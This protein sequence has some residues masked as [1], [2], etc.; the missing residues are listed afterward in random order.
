MKK[1]VSVIFLALCVFLLASCQTTITSTSSITT[2]TTTST[3]TLSTTAPK[4]IDSLT[5]EYDSLT[6]EAE[7]L[8]F[9][10][11]FEELLHTLHQDGFVFPSQKPIYVKFSPNQYH[12]LLDHSLHL[13]KNSTKSLSTLENIFFAIYGNFANYGLVY[14]LSR[15]YGEK[16]GIQME[17]LAE[18]SILDE[19]NEVNQHLLE[20]WYVGFIEPYSTPEESL[21]SKQLAVQL[22]TYLIENHGFEYIQSLLSKTNDL[23]EFDLAFT[24][25]RNQWLAYNESSIRVEVRPV[26]LAFGYEMHWYTLLWKSPRATWFLYRDYEDYFK[27]YI[28]DSHMFT[29]S[30]QE[31]VYLITTLEHQMAEMDLIF[32]NTNLNPSL[33]YH[34]VNINLIKHNISYFSRHMF[35]NSLFAFI[36]EYVHYLSSY[37]IEPYRW[38]VEGIAE[39][40]T[41]TYGYSEELITNLHE[42][43]DYFH[44]I[45]SIYREYTNQSVDITRDLYDVFDYYIF[46]TDDYNKEIDPRMKG[47]SFI[48]YFIKE[49]GE[50]TLFLFIRNISN[51]FDLTGKT[52]EELVEDWIQDVKSRFSDVSIDDLY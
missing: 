10:L 2:T 40:Y 7:L 51:A 13:Y 38:V 18:L 37:W 28:E 41:S 27:D 45:T 29:S 23:V 47:V 46:T 3:S 36:H 35:V 4:I 48:R 32:K 8:Q 17:P 16:L 26:P 42:Q 49:Y 44:P 14:G 39:Y 21:L 30:Q 15:Y 6:T 33:Q 50:E 20:L 12:L 43:E 11:D 31:L 19:I 5:I 25:I 1:L 24:E 34:D 9:N 22:V 52:Y